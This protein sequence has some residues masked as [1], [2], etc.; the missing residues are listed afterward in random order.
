MVTEVA[1]LIATGSEWV[2]P[3]ILAFVALA[4]CIASIVDA[5]IGYLTWRKNRAYDRR[6]GFQPAVVILEACDVR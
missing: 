4:G 3:L 2:G 5:S 6:L 1:S